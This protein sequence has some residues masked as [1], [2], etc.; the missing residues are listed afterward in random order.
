M[1]RAVVSLLLL[2]AGG[3]VA[4]CGG[5]GHDASTG[6]QASGTTSADVAAE[7]HS[8]G[9]SANPSGA[10]RS[11]TRAQAATFAHAVNLRLADVPG[12]KI[13]SEHEHET[14]AEKRLEHAML[15]CVGV[16]TLGSR[17]ALVEVSSPSFERETNAL[18]EGVSR[19]SASLEALSRQPKNWRLSTATAP[20]RASRTISISFSKARNTTE[21]SLA[22]YRLPKVPHRQLAR[23]G[24]SGGASPQPSPCTKW[25]CPSRLTS[26]ASF[27]VQPG[28]RY[29]RSALR[30]RFRRP[31]RNGCS[32]CCS[33]E[34]RRTAN[35]AF[36]G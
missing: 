16:G 14:A 34:R 29:L 13:V 5:N 11:L 30:G 21:R 6:A 8:S 15:R 20:G 31:P 33:L 2:A 7:A 27:T 24:A 4:A 35:E 9:G 25:R 17:H 22:R 10:D 12:F 28:S 1:R 19:K 36:L 3:L 26:W 32:R 23:R 18:D